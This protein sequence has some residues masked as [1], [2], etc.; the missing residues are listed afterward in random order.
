[1]QLTD[2]DFLYWFDPLTNILKKSK[3]GT[4][5]SLYVFVLHSAVGG[6]KRT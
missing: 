5:P 4:L 2:S 1:M 3:V 6:V